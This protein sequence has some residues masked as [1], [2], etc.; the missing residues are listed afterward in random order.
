MN[1]GVK[2]VNE[3]LKLFPAIELLTFYLDNLKTF[4][5]GFTLR[6]HFIS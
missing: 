2:R 3:P 6:T 4:G 5:S 1:E